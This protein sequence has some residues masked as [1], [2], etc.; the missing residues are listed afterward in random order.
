MYCYC[1]SEKKVLK[2]YARRKGTE[3]PYSIYYGLNSGTIYMCGHMHHTRDGF[4]L[5]F[6]VKFSRSRFC[7]FICEIHSYA[8]R[9]RRKASDEKRRCIF[10]TFAY[11]IENKSNGIP[12]MKL[13]IFVESRI[14]KGR[15]KTCFLLC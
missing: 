8:K 15:A 9:N 1:I 14:Q 2:I 12:N 7:S 6:L 10:V 11:M 13:K 3:Q 5:F 4:L